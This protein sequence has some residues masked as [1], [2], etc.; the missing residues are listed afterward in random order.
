MRE[1]ERGVELSRSGS[2]EKVWRRGRGGGCGARGPPRPAPWPCAPD[3]DRACRGRSPG[4]PGSGPSPADTREQRS[5][6]RSMEGRTL[7]ALSDLPADFGF[8]PPPD[9]RRG[10]CLGESFKDGGWP[11]GPQ[12]RGLSLDTPG[13]N[14]HTII[15]Q[16][17][18]IGDLLCAQRSAEKCAEEEGHLG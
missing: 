4:N 17:L 7:E 3:P 8:P 11:S 1:A 18:S 9:W 2:W 5:T 15:Q 16:T 10:P 6:R 13:A 12:G 14:V